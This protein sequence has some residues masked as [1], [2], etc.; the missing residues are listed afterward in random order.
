MKTKEM[1]HR[2]F[3]VCIRKWKNKI[4]KKETDEIGEEQIEGKEL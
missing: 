2:R 3:F 1:E 4:K